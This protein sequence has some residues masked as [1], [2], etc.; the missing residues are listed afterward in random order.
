MRYRKII[1]FFC[2]LVVLGGGLALAAKD[3]AAIRYRK[4]AARAQLESFYH[5][6]AALVIGNGKYGHG[7]DNLPGALRD[8]DEVAAALKKHGFAVTLKKNLT[9][10][11]FDAALLRFIQKYGQDK[12]NRL[13][14]YYSG[15]GHTES[16]GGEQAGYLVMV[17]AKDPARDMLGFEM[18]SIPMANLLVRARMIRSKHVLFLFDSC[19]SGNI[20]NA[21]GKA[22]PEHVS[23]AVKQP[24]RQFITSG[25]AKEPVPDTSFFKTLFL[26]IINGKRPEP[27]PDGYLTGEELGLFLKQKLPG[28]NPCQHP[29]YGKINDPRLDK[30]DFVFFL[31]PSGY[32]MGS[33][34]PQDIQPPMRAASLEVR[35]QPGNA[36]VRIL[37][38]GP[39][40]HA[41]MALAA[42]RYHVEVSASGYQTI[43]RWV[44]LGTGQ[45][46]VLDMQLLPKVIAAAPAPGAAPEAAAS[47]PAS[48]SSSTFTDPVTGMEFVLVKGDCYSMGSTSSEADDDERPVHDVCVDDF[49]MGKYEVTNAQ[50]IG[51]WP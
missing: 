33:E 46:L 37:N 27:V 29:Q 19:F 44:E 26:D 9:K 42:G 5:T 13:L 16:F 23:E 51:S 8:V 38:I 48:A 32:S 4:Q 10:S 49:Y 7:W 30:G 14:F 12:N 18:G 3:R 11:G 21:R 47:R 25:S 2:L 35:T 43:R 22:A 41:G 1:I 6:S 50:C 28:Y 24:V 15:H 40:Y 39:K 17:D 31:K 34:P 36:R 45:N 20:L